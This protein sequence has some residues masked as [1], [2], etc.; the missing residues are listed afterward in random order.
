LVF[1][2]HECN[3]LFLQLLNFYVGDGIHG[4]GL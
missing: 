2:S 1:T 3:S 4:I